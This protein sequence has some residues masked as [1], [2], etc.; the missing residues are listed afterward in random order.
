M[1]R[2][3]STR[4]HTIVSGSVLGL[5]LSAGSVLNAQPA[6]VTFVPTGRLSTTGKAWCYSISA[7]GTLAVG[8]AVNSS[9]QNVAVLYDLTTSPPGIHALGFLNS[10]YPDSS[11]NGVALDS[12]GVVHVC[13]TSK[14]ASDGKTQGFHWT[15]DRLGVGTFQ[16]IPFLSGYNA[17]TAERL[18]IA[19]DNTV[20]VTGQNSGTS[21]TQQ[22]YRWRSDLNSTLGLGFL[23]GSR[24]AGL[25]IT[26]RDG[27]TV[28]VGWAD[29]NFWVGGSS[30]PEAFKWT[31]TVDGDPDS[32]IA[33]QMGLDRICGGE[34]W[35]ISAGPNGIA[36]TT[37]NAD[38]AQVVPPGT[39]GLVEPNA[40]VI[41]PG[42]DN[43]LK[44]QLNPIGDDIDWPIGHSIESTSQS[45]H[46]A[47]S[48]NARYAVGEST[49][50]ERDCTPNCP[51]D[52]PRQAHLHDVHNRDYTTPD[53]CAGTGFFWPLGFLPGDNHSMAMGV[54]DGGGYDRPDGRE[55]LTVVGWSRHINYAIKAGSNGAADSA[56]QG[57][58]IQVVAVG[59]TGLASNAKVVDQGPNGKLDTA[60]TADDSIYAYWPDLNSE[61]QK[62]FA[63]F[64]SDSHPWG[65]DIWFLQQ[66][67][68]ADDDPGASA[69]SR[70]NGMVDLKVWLA[71]NGVDMTGWD[72]RQA[73][74]VSQDGKIIVGWGIHNG[75]EES[76]VVTVEFPQPGA[77]C[78]QTGWGSGT[79]SV[80]MQ[81]EC[82]NGTWLGN[83]TTCGQCAFCPT[84]SADTDGDGD[85]DQADFAIFQTCFTGLGGGVPGGCECFNTDADTDIDQDDWA[86]FEGQATGAG[87]SWFAH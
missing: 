48:P 73:T 2:R 64:I 32:G 30:R 7:D 60:P 43:T 77:C 53:N 37:A 81:E 3:N 19:S 62:A 71:S 79:C 70:F 4:M 8:K 9:S 66:H 39:T 47:I 16:A 33:P 21:G 41:S 86:A 6:A 51:G 58:D 82:T 56:A 13:G 69:A 65:H 35:Q 24:S 85:V 15:G 10:T 54:S 49:Y 46:R 31:P 25:D 52:Y 50:P 40:I 11:A 28:A 12:N 36:E 59:T 84:P 68:A 72:L 67:G 18:V 26:I 61:N 74:D 42:A 5:I 27:S 1:S 63:C 83:N 87:V 17:G 14:I 45:F 57:D 80:V 75:L 78:V 29:G 20:Y 34:G 76:F 23:T 22:G 55:G 44:G 38:N